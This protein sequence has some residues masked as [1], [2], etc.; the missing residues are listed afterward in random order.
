MIKANQRAINVDELMNKIREQVAQRQNYALP[1]GVKSRSVHLR[2]AV[3]TGHIEALVNNAESRAYVRTTW[4][5]KYNRFPLKLSKK[6][7]KLVFKVLEIIF[8][9]QRG[10]NFSLLQALREF[11]L[12]NRQL[13]EQIATLQ[14]QVSATD[15]RLQAM[16][17][18]VSATDT[19]LQ[20]MD[21]RHLRDDCYLKNDLA[22]QKRLIT[23]F[24]EEARQRLPERFNQDQ[25]QTLVNEEQ[26]LLD[27][28]Y[29][30]FEDQFR[31]SSKDII[32]RLKVYLPL[33][34]EAKIGKQDSPILDVG[35][36]RGEW[37]ELL[38]K[39]GYTA[40]GLDINRVMIDQCRAR[41][42]QVVEGD[43]ISFLQFLPDASLG[44]VTGFHIIEHL[45]FEV[46]M[47]LV[48]E[49][50]RVLKPGGLLIFETPN[51]RNILVGSGDFYRDPTHR[52]PI[53]PDT[54]SFIAESKGL[55]RSEVYFTEEKN[56]SLTF[57]KSSEKRFDTL[58]DYVNISR[59]YAMVA[60]KL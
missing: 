41:G 22:Q 23:L 2:S 25:L 26:H 59:D 30:A 31:G 43:I 9:D 14:A 3:E 24:L 40:Q 11:L 18:H 4:P 49:T 29:V 15:T 13:V 51:T 16:D 6:L 39:N 17:E 1:E 8:R 55:A 52:S 7:Q 50:V 21:E 10:F 60:Y 5:D 45:P 20:A 56:D 19:H 54:I 33:I 37:L 48:D 28:F 44:A 53:H 12:L 47:K 34:A 42:L 35:C 46:L 32:D 38:Q 57:I 58:N 36:G 27:A